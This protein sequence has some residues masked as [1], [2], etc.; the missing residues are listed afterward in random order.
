MKKKSRSFHERRVYGDKFNGQLRGLGDHALARQRGL[1]G[2][3]LGPASE[4]RKLTEEEKKAVEVA[5]KRDGRI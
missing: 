4:G 1:R 2:S 5:L 3:T